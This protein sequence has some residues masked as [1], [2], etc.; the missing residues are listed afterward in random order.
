MRVRYHF[1]SIHVLD[2]IEEMCA[3]TP[4]QGGICVRLGAGPGVYCTDLNPLRKSRGDIS[5]ECWQQWRPQTMEAFITVP[6]SLVE[7]CGGRTFRV[8]AEAAVPIVWTPVAAHWEGDDPW[9]PLAPGR[10]VPRYLRC[11]SIT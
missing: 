9:N 4:S 11:P 2:V 1:T 6:K 7:Y 5:Y 10:W 3:L 8:P